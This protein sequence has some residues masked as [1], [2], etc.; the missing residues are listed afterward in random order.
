M[1]KLN[2]KV[3]ELRVEAF[4]TTAQG[5]EWAAAEEQDDGSLACTEKTSC[6]HI[7]P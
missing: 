6:G 4:V 2:L 1:Q 7:C 3:D 5:R